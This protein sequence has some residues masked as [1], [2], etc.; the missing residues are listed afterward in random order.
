MKI[1]VCPE[2]GQ[3]NGHHLFCPEMP[4]PPDLVD[5]EALDELEEAQK[6]RNN[7][8]PEPSFPTLIDQD[9]DE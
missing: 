8:Y 3:W 1:F 5:D 4:E 7:Y 6:A 9:A 2:C